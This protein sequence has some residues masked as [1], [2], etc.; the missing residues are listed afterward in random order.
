[1]RASEKDGTRRE[2][3]ES[4]HPRDETLNERVYQWSEKDGGR[5][6]QRVNASE[7]KEAKRKTAQGKL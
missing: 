5:V 4:M 2:P 6:S 3:T 7:R 1:M